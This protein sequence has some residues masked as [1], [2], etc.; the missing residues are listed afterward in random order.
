MPRLSPSIHPVRRV[1]RDRR[2]AATLEF[3]L[4]AAGFFA[5][6][7]ATL[8]TAIVFFVQQSVQTAAETVAR[9]VL[10]GQI[11]AGTTQAQFRSQACQQLPA[12]LKCASLYADVRK[13]ADLGSAGAVGTA[14]RFD[15]A[16]RVTDTTRFEPGG[17]GD[18]VVLRLIYDWPIGTGPL[19]V[20]LRNQP[21]GSRTIV[22]TMVFKSEPFA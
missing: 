13:V 18:I 6:L 2:G 3:A 12:F 8:Q 7:I 22:G 5:L 16:G 4:C 11:P 14:V 10:T 19:G 15:V 1:F 21:D 9:R 17:A 20:D